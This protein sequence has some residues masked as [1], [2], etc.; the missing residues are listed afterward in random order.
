MAAL[1]TF[2]VE[3]DEKSGVPSRRLTNE[4]KTDFKEK[5]GLDLST[6]DD[7]IAEPKVLE[8]VQKCIEATNKNS[9]SR[10]AHIRKFKLLADDFSIPSGEFTP[11]LKLKRSVT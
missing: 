11:T 10:A 4:A 7:A 2:K 3:I 8:Y 9:V 5:L 1:I 6:S